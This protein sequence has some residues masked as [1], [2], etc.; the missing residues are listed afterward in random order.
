MTSNTSR[1]AVLASVA[2]LPALAIIPAT[3]LAS[4]PDI[5]QL[6]RKRMAVL[7]QLEENSAAYS[8]AADTL[9]AWSR[10]GLDCMAKDGSYCGIEVGWPEIE[11]PMLPSNDGVVNLVRPNLNE[12]RHRYESNP[13][14]GRADVRASYRA[15]VRQFIARV[16]EQRRLRNAAGLTALGESSDKLCTSLYEIEE[17]IQRACLPGAYIAL[18]AMMIIEISYDGDAGAKSPV[19]VLQ[20]LMPVLPQYLALEAQKEIRRFAEQEKDEEEAEAETAVQS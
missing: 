5:E 15:I 18:A 12:I 10:P 19:K 17:T 9:P 20:V 1:R 2:S 13:F 16:R 11:N 14:K 8:K 3:V 7:A 4:E 6:W